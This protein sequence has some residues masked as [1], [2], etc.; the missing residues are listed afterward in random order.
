MTAV[1]SYP[2]ST[3]ALRD[4][5][6]TAER[7][8]G[9]REIIS[10]DGHSSTVVHHH[11]HGSWG[12]GPHWGWYPPA[13]TYHYHNGGS[14]R[15]DNDYAWVA[16]P[17]AGVGLTAAYFLGSDYSQWQ[18]SSKGIERLRERQ[19]ETAIE[20]N[21]KPAL[22]NKMT[23]VFQKQLNLLNHQKD[24]AETGLMMKTAMAASAAF[25]IA[26]ALASSGG[27]V[28]LGFGGAVVSG[29]A[30][31]FKAGFDSADD[32]DKT[33]ARDLQDAVSSAESALNATTEKTSTA[34][35]TLLAATA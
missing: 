22:W 29:G 23:Q 16:I 13:P 32:T 33:R 17:A 10:S 20:L 31:L 24:D 19:I 8:I 25:A 18:R 4:A 9:S 1:Q 35:E 26:G 2:A 12:W 15:S 11:H 30:M 6:E 27:L 3:A 5:K 14:G 7:V 34:G 28:A 21:T